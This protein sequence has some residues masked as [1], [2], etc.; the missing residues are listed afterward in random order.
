VDVWHCD[1]LG[2]Y[3]DVTDPGFSTAGRK[4]FGATRSLEATSY[5][6]YVS[7]LVSGAGGSHPF[8]DPF[9]GVI[10]LGL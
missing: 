3:S 8:Q 10:E 4:F 1:A 9:L 6:G 7:G 2:V 5:R